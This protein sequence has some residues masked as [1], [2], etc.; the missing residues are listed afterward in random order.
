MR[1]KLRSAVALEEWIDSVPM[2]NR[3]VG[4]ELRVTA[5]NRADDERPQRNGDLIRQGQV[6]RTLRKL[7]YLGVAQKL[8]VVLLLK[9]GRRRA[10]QRMDL[11]P[12]GAVRIFRYHRQD[13]FALRG[14]HTRRRAQEPREAPSRLCHNCRVTKASHGAVKCSPLD[15]NVIGL[16]GT[17]IPTDSGQRALE[18][19]ARVAPEG[20]APGPPRVQFIE[21]E[22]RLR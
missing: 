20:G 15:R 10:C 12:G 13:R 18:E 11:I 16:A 7:G 5:G 4:G 19:R 22:E 6:E 9:L 8:V 2:L 17:R 14:A 3:K 21:P 1:H